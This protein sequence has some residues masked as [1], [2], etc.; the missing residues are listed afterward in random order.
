MAKLA[1]DAHKPNNQTLLCPNMYEAFIQ[2]L[3]IRRLMGIGYKTAK[4]LQDKL[5][6]SKPQSTSPDHEAHEDP[7]EEHHEWHFPNLTV[8]YIH[9]HCRK[10]QFVDWFGHKQGDQ[11]W[12]LLHGIDHA[13]VIPTPLIPTQISIEDSFRQC[14]S[15]QAAKKRLL[16][17]AVDFI[18]RLESELLT[19]KTWVKYPTTLRLTTRVRGS[20]NNTRVIRDTRISKS[21][22]MPVDIFEID[23]SIEDRASSLVERSLIPMLKKLVTEPFD[24]TLLNIAAAQLS[25]SRPSGSIHGYFAKEVLA[26]DKIMMRPDDIDE[27]VWADLPSDIQRELVYHHATAKATGTIE[28]TVRTLDTK[29]D[30]LQSDHAPPS[31]SIDD[32][33]DVAFLLRP[34]TK[35]RYSED[36]MEFAP[37]EYETMVMLDDDENLESCHVCGS[38][39]FP[40]AMR[41]HKLFH[42]MREGD[43]PIP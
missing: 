13:P 10:E 12:E 7:T 39:M 37:S 35:R 30:M 33:N 16:E 24:L 8:A 21:E 40:W 29:G 6:V 20:T 11:I 36:N 28:D 4:T 27:S 23:Q 1:A 14:A 22:R 31:K 38:S 42:E 18:K 34:S 3:A 43:S 19:D 2:P 25:K 17:L 26:S 5:Y 32:A 15:I 41:A 9:E